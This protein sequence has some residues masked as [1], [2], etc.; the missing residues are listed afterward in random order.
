MLALL[1]ILM[2]G[3]A[4]AQEGVSADIL[5]TV[6]DQSGAVIQGAQ[7]SV[8]NVGT[9]ISSNTKSDSKGEY[10]VQYLQIGTY[11]V[12]VDAKGTGAFSATVITNPRMA[13]KPVVIIDRR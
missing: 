4:R 6:T 11:L 3:M 5:G 2:P 12:T 10:L 9:G 7:I 8:K 1:V 13:H